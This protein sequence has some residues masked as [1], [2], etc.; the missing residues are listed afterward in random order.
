MKRLLVVLLVVVAAVVATTA[1]AQTA[2][3]VTMSIGDVSQTDV[4]ATNPDGTEGTG[5]NTTMT[6]PVTLS[7]PAP[8]GGVSVDYTTISGTATPGVDYL[9]TS[10]TLA[11]A[12][13]ETQGSIVVTIVGD[14]LDEPDETFRVALSNAVPQSITIDGGGVATGTIPDD[15]DPPS[16]T[17]ADA[18]VQGGAVTTG[19]N[20]LV[21]FEVKL[22]APS[23]RTVQVDYATEDDTAIACTK[24][25]CDSP[26]DGDYVPLSG[27]LTFNPGVTSLQVSVVAIGD[28]L[29][30]NKRFRLKLAN[31]THL[32]STSTPFRAADVGLPVTIRPDTPQEQTTTITGLT[33]GNAFDVTL[34]DP[35]ANGQPVAF[36]FRPTYVD[37]VLAGGTTLSSVSARF[38]GADEGK[39]ITVGGVPNT[40]A[41]VTTSSQIT[42]ADDP[43]LPTNTGIAFSYDVDRSD[44]SLLGGVHQTLAREA[45][46][47]RIASAGPVASIA[48]ATVAEGPAGRD[49]PATLTVTLDNP[50]PQ[51]LSVAYA[52]VDGTAKAGQDYRPTQGRLTFAPGQTS[53]TITVPIVGNDLHQA[54]RAFTVQLKDPTDVRL[55]ATGT[56][57]TV[58]ITDDDAAPRVVVADA[59]IA[60]PRAG[61]ATVDV[62][63]SLSAPSGRPVDVEY[64]TEDGTAKAGLHYQ[65]SSGRL[66]FAP[67]ETAKAISIAV[68]GDGVVTDDQTFHVVVTDTD[69]APRRAT[70][71][72][73]DGDLTDELT[74]RASINDVTARLGE[75]GG[76][77]RFTVRL[78]RPLTRTSL[79][80]WR[81]V[82]GSA[83][84]LRDYVPG[85]GLLLF[86]PGQLTATIDVPILAEDLPGN[87][88]FSVS[89]FAPVALAIGDGTGEAVLIPTRELRL[90]GRVSGG[91]VRA[92][93][94]LCRRG[95]RC[96]G[97]R[98]RWTAPSGGRVRAQ[99]RATVPRTG[100]KR[101]S[102]PTT[103]V[104]ADRRITVRRKGAGSARVKR[105]SGARA[106][107]LARRLR[108]ARVRRVT[109]RVTHVDRLG[110]QRAYSQ[111]I[112]LRQ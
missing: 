95:R 62:A 26:D 107:R 92:R 54:D 110:R 81:T 106:E 49:T 48:D 2:S 70:V 73:V 61:T 52:T 88:T 67:G 64:R 101:S 23:G 112:R 78:D 33:P 8:Q 16:I 93:D 27:T 39:P 72:L 57:A 83:K 77:A 85:T 46:F 9:T 6:F 45:A 86:A 11:I 5:A 1:T 7:A 63:V 34:A 24:Q 41:A 38:T 97:L 42:L 105:A 56:T 102:K 31:V 90:A 18:D 28:S 68:A 3:A 21:I 79:V 80:A 40:I 104:V 108:Q 76:V 17:V 91:S 35:V 66:T 55:G 12:E 58:R 50:S 100:A 84:A 82:D 59:V 47:G 109:V 87:R 89:L 22:S 74:P 94:V 19:T 10:G 25:T 60:E 14:A 37:G 30:V 36:R 43:G 111:T 71:T 13:G 99:I 98:V 32:R 69:G 96:A 4:T 15:D 75:D 51:A 65:Q 44:G 53:R 20:R 29:D 103:V